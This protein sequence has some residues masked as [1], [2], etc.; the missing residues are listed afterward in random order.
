MILSLITIV[1]VVFSMTAQ[2]AMAAS[3]DTA[4]SDSA[5]TTASQNISGDEGDTPG[6]T[7]AS[8]SEAAVG[9]GS[10]GNTAAKAAK[11]TTKKSAKKAVVSRNDGTEGGTGTGTDTTSVTVSLYTE[12]RET[13]FYTG[14][15]ITAYAGVRISGQNTTLQN[16]TMK[17]TIP[18]KY[19]SSGVKA[20]QGNNLSKD[21]EVTWDDDNY[22]I[23]FSYKPISGGTSV[24]LPFIFTTKNY[25]TPDGTTIPLQ[26]QYYDQEGKELGKAEL[27]LKNL[28]QL[29]TKATGRYTTFSDNYA[30][31]GQTTTSDDPDK[32]DVDYAK[33]WCANAPLNSAYS[34]LGIYA[35]G[36]YR[37]VMKLLNGV[38]YDQSWQTNSY[39]KNATYDPEAKTVTVDVPHP[40]SSSILEISPRLKCPNW[41]Y[42][43]AIPALS[44]KIIPLDEDGNELMTGISDEAT[45]YITIN[46]AQVE[47][48]VSVSKSYPQS[49]NY[50]EAN[51]DRI[52]TWN[53]T[54]TNRST[55]KGSMD[56][57]PEGA[58]DYYVSK[59]EDG[60]LDSHL[61]FDSFTLK[62][63]SSISDSSVLEN[64]VLYGYVSQE[65]VEIARNI[66]VDE[67]VQIPESI[68]KTT[69]GNYRNIKLVFN[70]KVKLKPGESIKAAV[71]TKV[72]PQDW[73]Q[74]GEQDPHWFFPGAG[75]L[76]NVDLRNNVWVDGSYGKDTKTYSLHDYSYYQIR[77]NG[78]VNLST[79]ASGSSFTLNQIAT[80]TSSVNVYAT[81]TTENG[82]TY[83]LKNGKLYMILP[84]GWEYINNDKNPTKL[85]YRSTDGMWH[86]TYPSP[87]ML[88]DFQGTGQ[89]A[90]EFDVP[91]DIASGYT[92]EAYIHLKATAS[93]PKGSS[94]VTSWLSYE[95][96][97]QLEIKANNNYAGDQYDLNGNGSVTD[98]INMD[99][100]YI[101]FVPPK[102]VVGIKLI[103]QDLNSLTPSTT[104][105]RDLG[106]DFYYGFKIVNE[107][108]NDEVEKLDLLD[109]LPYVG[110]LSIV[111]NQEGK[112]NERGSLF[113]T[114]LTGPVQFVFNGQ[115]V[116]PEANGFEIYYSTD[117]PENGNLEA[118]LGRTFTKTVDD[119]S[120]VTMIRIVMKKG[121]KIG[122]ED[123]ILLAAPAMVQD[124]EDAKARLKTDDTAS[125]SF[126]YASSLDADTTFTPDSY[127]EALKTSIPI[128]RYKVD[129]TVYRD[130]NYDGSLSKEEQ[131]LKGVKVGLFNEAG[132]KIDE[133]ETDANGYYSFN[134]FKR[135]KYSV[136]VLEKPD[137][138][139][140]HGTVTDTDD[141]FPAS[142]ISTDKQL[143]NSKEVGNDV[144]SEGASENFDLEP[145]NREATVNSAL[146]EKP[147]T[148]PVT[149]V[150]KGEAAPVD[151]VDVTLTGLE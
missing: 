7:A 55:Y 113:T 149:K 10:G 71:T 79:S 126:A 139:Y 123:S 135:G 118:N 12:S 127:I 117:T 144:N 110:D 95:N 77:S 130:Y 147:I 73:E 41:K 91:N 81:P 33:V 44:T 107:M 93:T 23:T 75:G 69:E 97:G 70:D 51:K 27:T 74:A 13:E 1:M 101:N 122:A 48:Y 138:M 94:K 61:Y 109:I 21:P 108:Q 56:N 39:M 132:D 53:L 84:N 47:H 32:L 60:S 120:K 50:T 87:K 30:V 146:E 24:E 40:S 38:I 137:G 145:N 131:T 143:V 26:A 151:T 116:D 43:E 104:A 64:N 129:G 9:E 28:A 14:S 57:V 67:K 133:A 2:F 20:S 106:D 18:K 3:A 140:F 141:I 6:D 76:V 85:E 22:Y 17:V 65:W 82:N 72:I 5:G 29:Q 114:K 78:W 105:Y 86:Y 45:S 8:D 150:W 121:T 90:L 111:K 68:L 148:V 58:G 16:T 19:L 11:T 4:G 98:R 52:S 31:E 134:V 89:C 54:V 112:Y 36:K 124:D 46:P 102:E 34:N 88:Y 125:N 35:P 66:K 100:A 42:G 142:T 128:T 99:Y 62:S 119:W 115:L 25:T 49:Y 15:E 103:G 59:I 80:V 37:V 92:M 63:D 83:M 136:K 96:N